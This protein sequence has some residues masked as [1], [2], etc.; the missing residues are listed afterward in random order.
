ML[1]KGSNIVGVAPGRYGTALCALEIVTE[2]WL[3]CMQESTVKAEE[4]AD[5]WSLGL[6]C[7]E[8]FRGRP[9]FG[10]EMGDDH[11]IAMLLGYASFPEFWVPTTFFPSISWLPYN[12]Q[13]RSS[14]HC[15]DFSPTHLVEQLSC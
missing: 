9:L 1:A 11:V 7:F 4:A 8:L 3:H 2:D 5:V 10:N 13:T 15:S 14:I 6:V 12:L